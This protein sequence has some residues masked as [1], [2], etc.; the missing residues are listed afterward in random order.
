MFRYPLRLKFGTFTALFFFIAAIVVVGLA[1]WRQDSLAQSVG[2]DAQWAAYKVDRETVQLRTQLMRADESP[3]ALGQFRLRFELLFSRVNLLRRGELAELVQSIPRAQAVIAELVPRL[4]ALDEQLYRLESL[5]PEQRQRLFDEFE[6]LTTYSEQL[7]VAINTHLGETATRERAM[8]QSFYRLLL[9]LI[10]AMSLAGTLVVIFLFREARESAE[11][12]RHMETLGRRLEVTAQRAEMANQAKSEFIA[13]VSHE[14]RTPLNGV[15]GMSELLRGRPLDQTTRRYTQIIHDSAGVLLSLINDLLDFSKI[16]AG[17][18]ELERLPFAL[19]AL[20][21]R[22]VALFGARAADKRLELTV[23][24]DARLPDSLVGDPERFQQVV[25]NLLSNAI[26]F[27]ERGEIVLAASPLTDERLLIE[28]IDPGCGIPLEQQGHLFEPFRQGD[29]STARRYGGT[30]LGLAICR[31]LVMAMGGEIGFESEV[32]KGS[33]FW[34]SL[35]LEEAEKS[36]ERDVIQAGRLSRLPLASREHACL[37][38]VEDNAINQQVA[39]AMLERLG[40]HVEIAA[41]GREALEKAKARHYDLIFMDVEMPDMDGLEVTRRMRERSGWMREVPIVAMTAGALGGDE[42]RCRAAGMNDYLA[43]PLYHEAL[44]TMLD[45]YLLRD[46][47]SL[48]VSASTPES[49]RLEDEAE[50]SFRS[51]ACESECESAFQCMPTEAAPWL[52]ETTFAEL[53]QALGHQGMQLLQKLFMASLEER[54]TVIEEAIAAC[55]HG[56]IRQLAHLFKG[57]AGSLG[58]RRMMRLAHAL[59]QAAQAADV[60]R[61]QALFPLLR[62]SLS[63]SLEAFNDRLAGLLDTP[64]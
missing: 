42:E 50:G 5:S 49:P 2:G 41:S 33:R 52:D 43:K 53:H 38:L 10:L 26:K 1:L 63:P 21:E 17:K 57:E 20:L 58:L 47:P 19:C 64:A 9:A 45:R 40:C 8:L 29:A 31:R 37:L 61:Q 60:A 14:I 11:T 15:I 51:N 16:E 36:D 56:R 28:V 44:S 25:L 22:T 62:E 18:L 30:G 13:T 54:L 46:V 48:D 34:F 12:R 7:V 39:T 59:E 24:V 3:E 4:E 35:P 6:P 32:G 55:E 23:H 27:S